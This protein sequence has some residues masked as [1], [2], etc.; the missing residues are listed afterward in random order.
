MLEGPQHNA[1]AV[2]FVPRTH[3]HRWHRGST[4]LRE[5]PRCSLCE[6]DPQLSD[7]CVQV[8]IYEDVVKEAGLIL[9]A[10]SSSMQ[11]AVAASVAAA[12]SECT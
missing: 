10:G 12:A 8:V 4:L 5:H 9:T 1:G 2:G 11:R 3:S 6:D 7:A